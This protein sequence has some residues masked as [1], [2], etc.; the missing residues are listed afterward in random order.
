MVAI[1]VYVSFQQIGCT[2]CLCGLPG[3]FLIA[4]RLA[5]WCTELLRLRPFFVSN[6]LVEGFLFNAIGLFNKLIVAFPIFV[7]TQ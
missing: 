1:I 7:L 3:V 4:A 6:V 5:H 2:Q